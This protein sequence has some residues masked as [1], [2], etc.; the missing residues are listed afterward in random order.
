VRQGLAIALVEAG[1]QPEA[2][3]V[4]REAIPMCMKTGNVVAAALIY[5]ALLGSGETFGLAK[6]QIAA[7]GDALKSVKRYASAAKVYAAVL[8]AAPGDIKAM[9]GLIAVAQTFAQQRETAASAVRIYDHLIAHCAG[10]PLL[11]FVS[12]ERAKL[13]RKVV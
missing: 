3:D 7:L 6:E 11:D 4:A 2:V 5:E 10:S 8:N 12:T 1:R 9:K 13:E